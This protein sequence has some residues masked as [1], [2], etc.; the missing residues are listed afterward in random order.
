MSLFSWSEEF[1]LS[2]TS[3][4]AIK[5][6]NNYCY[7]IILS[8]SFAAYVFSHVGEYASRVWIGLHRPNKETKFR[9]SNSQ[10]LDFTDWS[11]FP[12]RRRL[13]LRSCVISFYN[14]RGSGYWVDGSCIAR[15][16]FVCKITR[17]TVIK[18]EHPGTCPSGWRKFDRHCYFLENN[19]IRRI[20]WSEARKQCLDKGA[21]LASIHSTAEQNFIHNTLWPSDGR[22]WIGLNDRR[23]EKQMVW[24]D[25]SPFDYS[26]WDTG[27]PSD[28]A[29][30]QN[31]IEMYGSVG[32]WND[33]SC[34]KERGF[35][36]KKELGI[37][38]SFPFQRNNDN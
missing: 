18:P 22:I 37:D 27:E 9:W 24:S 33:L 2:K 5:P 8:Q 28:N 38:F 35:V 36:C 1:M 12:V 26:Y 6:L 10:P 14:S 25:G 34:S 20:S 32:G 16:P 11:A 3:L 30:V 13:H 19:P 4:F 23:I 21:D 31:C 29:G 15:N 7:H 17:E